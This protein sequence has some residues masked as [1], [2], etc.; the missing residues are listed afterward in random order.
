M[1]PA[2]ISFQI[3]KTDVWHTQ[4]PI[5]MQSD[6]KMLASEPGQSSG[7]RSM[8]LSGA[9][10]HV[11]SSLVAVGTNTTVI[12]TNQKTQHI[13]RAEVYLRESRE[14]KNDIG[15]KVTAVRTSSRIPLCQSS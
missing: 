1:S 14:R 7:V 10:E 5:T 2:S 15:T 9:F 4:L 8:G 6:R 11:Q 13:E 3:G 12:M